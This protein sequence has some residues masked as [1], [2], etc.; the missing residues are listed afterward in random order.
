MR[1]SS[2]GDSYLDFYMIHSSSEKV[3]PNTF[4]NPT[5][6]AFAVFVAVEGGESGRDNDFNALHF[7]K[8]SYKLEAGHL[9]SKANTWLGLS[10]HFKTSSW[11]VHHGYV[12]D[13]K[14]LRHLKIFQSAFSASEM[15]FGYSHHRF[16][17]NVVK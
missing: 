12:I 13:R 17:R 15:G 6:L 16:G 10:V 8:G 11:A 4:F 14:A 3:Y 2:S 9:Q 1:L 5:N 7:K